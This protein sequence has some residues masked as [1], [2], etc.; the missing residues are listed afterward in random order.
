MPIYEGCPGSDLLRNPTITEKVCPVCGN[1]LEIFSIDTEVTCENCG[2]VA[3]NDA[4]TCA[5]WCKYAEKCLGP[6]AYE[7]LTGRK[8][9]SACQTD[10]GAV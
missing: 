6:E 1:T 7:R 5:K 9:E 8:A 2:F 3:F 10:G 4:L